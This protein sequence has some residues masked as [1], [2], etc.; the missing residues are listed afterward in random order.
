MFVHKDPISIHFKAPVDEDN[1]FRE[2]PPLV[3]MEI[4]KMFIQATW[5]VVAIVDECGLS[6]KKL[7]DGNTKDLKFGECGCA[8]FRD[9]FSKLE[10]EST[11]GLVECPHCK[12]P[13]KTK[14]IKKTIKL[15]KLSMNKS[16]AAQLLNSFN[17]P[18]E[19]QEYEYNGDDIEGSGSESDY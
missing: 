9:A 16:K 18:H 19:P 1:V 10:K 2:K 6:H 13:F 7:T 11:D 8:F 15:N 14:L 12:I 5:N 4:K 17:D 3:E